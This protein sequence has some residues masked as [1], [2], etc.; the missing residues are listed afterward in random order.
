VAW[1]EVATIAAIQTWQPVGMAVSDLFRVSYTMATPAR[2]PLGVLRQ[3]WDLGGEPH[4]EGYWTKLYPKL[5]TYE[6]YRVPVPP[7]FV[8]AGIFEREIQVRSYTNW[9]WTLT[10]EQWL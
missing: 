3:A 1:V 6:I 7:E 5:A 2:P 8:D 9:P 4:Y 10:L